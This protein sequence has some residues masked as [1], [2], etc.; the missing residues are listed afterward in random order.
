MIAKKLIIIIFVTV[1][2]IS[3]LS[4]SM[5][6]SYPSHTAGY[7]NCPS[8]VL[9]LLHHKGYKLYEPPKTILQNG[10]KWVTWVT[11][12]QKIDAI[13]ARVGK[14]KEPM[15]LLLSQ[16]FYAYINILITIGKQF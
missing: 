4:A 13:Q 14:V 6:Q 3:S 12:P 9:Y 10:A 7:I 1:M 16:D 5:D 2:E 8:W 15:E 11:F